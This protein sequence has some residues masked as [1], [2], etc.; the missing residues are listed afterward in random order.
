MTELRWG[1]P[2]DK[3]IQAGL[4]RGVLYPKDNPAVAWNGLTDITESGGQAQSQYYVN[5]RLFLTTVTPREYT[6]K[7]SCVTFPDEFSDICGIVEATDGLYLDSQV[8]DSF[9]LS[10]RTMYGDGVNYKIH[11]LYSVTAAMSDVQ[12]QTLDDSVNPTPFEFDLAA[13]PQPITGFRPT[14]HAIVD[15]RNI[16]HKTVVDIEAMLYGT[17]NTDPYLPSLTTLY[18]MMNY[19]D[20]VVIRDNGDGTWTAE[21]SYKHITVDFET[22][23]FVIDGVNTADLGGGEYKVASTGEAIV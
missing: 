7:L 6:A 14:A 10:Y 15:T 22:G 23:A 5:G 19:G 17:G 8:P 11:L 4:D 13:V 9:G 18:E 16:E 2:E 20:I 1:K 3:I 21:G 12:Y